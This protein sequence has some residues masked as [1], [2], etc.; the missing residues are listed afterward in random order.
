M[1]VTIHYEGRLKDPASL[2]KVLGAA[3]DFA[4]LRGW[5]QRRFTD[6]SIHLARVRNEEDWDYV[7]P[8]S[9]IELTPNDRCDPIRLEFDKD[10]YIQEFTKTQFAGPDTH[11][12]VVALLREL[13]PFFEDLMVDDEGEFWDS[14]DVAVL[15]EHIEACNRALADELRKNPRATGP[16]KLPSGRWIDLME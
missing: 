5:P 13:S 9:G 2:S 3:A 15:T 10:F 16:V 8:T 14:G 7:G 11:A 12:D 1:G 4:A 6:G